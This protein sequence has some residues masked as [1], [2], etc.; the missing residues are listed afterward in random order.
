M[1]FN[2]ELFSFNSLIYCLKTRGFENISVFDTHLYKYSF[3]LSEFWLNEYLKEFY[4]I[5]KIII[6][7]K[8]YSNIISELIHRNKKENI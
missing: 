1:I 2:K 4:E 5:I 6:K 7:S 8:Y 3:F